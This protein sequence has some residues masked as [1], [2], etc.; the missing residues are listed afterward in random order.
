M[1]LLTIARL[2]AEF[3]VGPLPQVGQLYVLEVLPGKGDRADELFPAHVGQYAESELVD[4]FGAV[5][6]AFCGPQV[7]QAKESLRPL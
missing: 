6:V 7:A 5:A 4:T 3:A 2:A 1:L